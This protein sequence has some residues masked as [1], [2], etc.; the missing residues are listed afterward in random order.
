MARIGR[1]P[2]AGVPLDYRQRPESVR[3]NV[4][5]LRA[6]VRQCRTTVAL[7]RR[8]V[9]IAWPVERRDEKERQSHRG[10][11]EEDGSACRF[12]LR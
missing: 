6:V 7:R 3:G 5:W 10:H 11:R 4:R 1:R 12:R 2:G 8:T 9:G